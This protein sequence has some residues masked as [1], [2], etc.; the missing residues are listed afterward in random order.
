VTDMLKPAIAT[1]S[2]YLR[3]LMNQWS[4][5]L[6]ER[7]RVNPSYVELPKNLMTDSIVTLYKFVNQQLDLVSNTRVRLFSFCFLL[8]KETCF[9]S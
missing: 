3:N 9:W 6:L 2:A 8:F 5:R 4:F 7:D 1:Y